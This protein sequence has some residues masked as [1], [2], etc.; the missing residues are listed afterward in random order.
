MT[1]DRTAT[2][3]EVTRSGRWWA[4]R[5]PSMPGV[6]SQCRR[7]DQVDGYAREAI[8]LATDTPPDDVAELDIR[9]EPP[10]EVAG[11]VSDANAA[12]DAARLATA[13]AAD[14][15]RSAIAALAASGYTT[16]DIG[17]LLGLSHQRVS[18]LLADTG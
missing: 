16:R 11:L 4:I 1:T 13:H 8:G 17:A 18:Q 9:T 3:V 2:V 5:V 12:V 7:L 15:R 14:A 6:F 10:A